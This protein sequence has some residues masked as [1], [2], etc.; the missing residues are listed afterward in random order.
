MRK[1]AALISTAALLVALWSAVGYGGN[2]PQPICEWVCVPLPPP[3]YV[4]CMLY[5]PDL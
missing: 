4:H 2:K 3:I 5:C 1:I